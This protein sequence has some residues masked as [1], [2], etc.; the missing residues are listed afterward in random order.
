MRPAAS[1][2]EAARQL[3]AAVAET[4]RATGASVALVYLLPPGERVLHL[5]VVSGAP[6]RITA[7]WARIDLGAP[8][9][10]IAYATGSA[11]R[12]DDIALLLIQAS[13]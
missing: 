5:A 4:V 7:P 13:R 10:F 9:P 12:H 6:R 11:P 1:A 8:I 2:S 3:D